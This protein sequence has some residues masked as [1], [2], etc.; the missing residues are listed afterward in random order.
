MELLER[1]GAPFRIVATANSTEMVR[2]LVATGIGV[3]LLNMRPRGVQPYAGEGTLCL[4]ISGS[5]SGVTLSLGFAPGPKRRLVQM[6][7][8]SCAAYFED[9][10]SAELIVPRDVGVAG[11]ID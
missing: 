8:D 9:P 5:T 1:S 2:S 4:P 7:V 10:N 6:F 3:A 11:A